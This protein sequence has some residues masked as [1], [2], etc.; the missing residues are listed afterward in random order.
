MASVLWTRPPTERHFWSKSYALTCFIF[1]DNRL[2]TQRLLV[3]DPK[4]IRHIYHS[5]Y[6]IRKQGFRSE[7]TTLMTGPGLASASGA[8]AHIMLNMCYCALNHL[9]QAKYIGANAESI[10]RPLGLLRR[11]LTSRFSRRT[12]T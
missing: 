12:P 5:G 6:D 2:Q 7:L 10:P 9:K 4:A 3:S 1:F 8:S 11:A